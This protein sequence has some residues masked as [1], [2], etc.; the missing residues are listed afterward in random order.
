[1]RD[2]NKT[3]PVSVII[4]CYCSSDTIE[5]AVQ[6][7]MDQTVLPVELILIDDASTDQG[8]TL[9]KLYALQQRHGKEIRVLVIA[10]KENLGPAGARNTGWGEASEEYLAFLDA[11]DSWHPQKIAIQYSFMAERRHIALS[12]HPCLWVEPGKGSRFLPGP[13]PVH[14][15]SP[16]LLS[17]SNRFQTPS[18]MLKRTLPYRFR[19]GMHYCED[20]LLWRQIVAG[21]H[22][23]WR[24]ELPLAFLYKAPFGASGLSRDPWKVAKGEFTVLGSIP[25]CTVAEKALK[26]LIAAAIIVKYLRR[27]IIS[28]FRRMPRS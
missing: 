23:A 20:Y 19:D 26:P 13:L 6:S 9:E 10:L 3:A 12:G 17:F 25:G 16:Y 7:V 15:V 5:R 28:P 27:R 14:R 1:M 18:V 11:D 8:K 22:E 24:I 2:K 21:G 4:P